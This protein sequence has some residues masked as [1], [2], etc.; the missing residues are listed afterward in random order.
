MQ[1]PKVSII[2]GVYNCS[3]TLN[4]AI[5]SILTQ[6]YSNW[7][8]II[9]DDGSNDNTFEIL[10]EY[11]KND[12]R[13]ILLKNEKNMGLNFTLNKCLERAS[14]EYV[15]RMDGDDISLPE[16]FEK[17][18]KFLEENPEFSLVSTSMIMFD[19][20]GDW[21]KLKVIERPTINDFC[22]HAPFFLHAAVII[23]KGVFLEVGGY[24]VK[25]QLLRV[26][27][28]HLWYKIYSKGYRGANL[29]DV[30]YKM[31]DD[32]N[33]VNR[34]TFSSRMHGIYVTWVGFKMVKMPWYK[35]I[36]AIKTTIME[37]LK[38][39]MPK[40]IYKLLH[41]YKQRKEKV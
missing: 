39:I 10:E 15:A 17:Q 41:K 37:F 27:D 35:Y 38:G 13:F 24:T 40:F 12:S 33:A 21:G 9:C 36:Y 3:K 16:R 4:E 18:V 20:T 23:R 14:G 2:M 19:E 5:D 31:R 29:T 28:C 22:N 11:A 34:R 32:R 1:T 8:F 26:E 30:L 25:K 6:T 7:E